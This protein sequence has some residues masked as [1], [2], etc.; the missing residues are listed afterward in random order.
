MR[1]DPRTPPQGT[2]RDWLDSRANAGGLPL[3]S[4]RQVKN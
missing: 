3:F 1:F 4:L 2:V